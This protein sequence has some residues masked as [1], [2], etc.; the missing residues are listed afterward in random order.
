MV[1]DCRWRCGDHPARNRP[2]DC[3]Q[4][5]VSIRRR[6]Q[7]RDETGDPWNGRLLEWA[8]ASPPPA[9][10]FAV[11]PDIQSQDAYWG[12]EAACSPAGRPLGEEPR[13]ADIE[14]P[15]NSPTLL[16]D[17]P[18]FRVDLAHLV[19][20]GPRRFRLMQLSSAWRD[21]DEYIVPAETVARIDRASKRAQCGARPAS[22]GAMTPFDAAAGRKH[23]DRLAYQREFEEDH[24]GRWAGIETHH[25]RLRLLDFPA[26]RHHHVL[27]LL[28]RLRGAGSAT[29]PRGTEP[30]G[31]FQ[32]CV[33]LETGISSLFQFYRRRRRKF[34]AQARSKSWFIWRDGREL[35]PWSRLSYH[36]DSGSSMA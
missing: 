16:R 3:A 24:R 21:T 1:A 11:L 27:R 28:R 23:T 30:R 7:L 31:A 8:T 35:H 36:R 34:G 33:G 5:A 4:L 22:G 9:F 2:A 6:D 10:N 25:H 15:R 29:R 26:E 19:D 13:Y 20:S 12:V 18:W 17:H 32:S 14:M